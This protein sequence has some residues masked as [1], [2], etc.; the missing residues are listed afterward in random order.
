[1]RTGFYFPTLIR[2]RI[3][4]TPRQI[5]QRIGK[6]AICKLLKVGSEAPRKWYSAGI[7]TRHWPVLVKHHGD[8]LS[9]EILEKATEIAQLPIRKR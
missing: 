7:P 6:S 1:M 2:M 9:Y 4:F 3:V 8:W 5:V